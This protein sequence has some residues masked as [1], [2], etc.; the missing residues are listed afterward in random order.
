MGP[1]TS[2]ADRVELLS[3]M[4]VAYGFLAVLFLM[5][6]I[7]VPYPLAV[8]FHA[9]L[10]LMAIYYWSIYRPSILPSWLVFAA[11]IMFDLLTGMPFLGL[12]AV[13]FLLARMAIKD[14]RRFLVGQSFVM[15]WFGFCIL[16]TA[17]YG[18]Q[19][20]AFSALSMSWVPLKDFVPSLALGMVL[21]PLLYWFLHLTHKVLPAPVER[22]KSRLGSQKTDM[23]L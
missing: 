19:W 14:Q 1:Y 18:F 2:I 3:R 21:F 11:G 8:L 23:P 15:V 12:N 17:F 13:L 7:A 6:V 9:P 4:S 5:S 20:G 10:L 22:A 16:D